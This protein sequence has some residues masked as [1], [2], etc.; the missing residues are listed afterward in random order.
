MEGEIYHVYNRG[1]HKS[2]IFGIP[3]DYNRFQ[4]LLYLANSRVPVDFREVLDRSE[5]RTF[6][7]IFD[8]S[9]DQS[10]VSVLAYCLMP[11]HFHLVVR[12][13]T[14]GGI[15]LF[16]RKLATAYSMYFNTKYEH[17]GT[18]F[19]GKFKSKHVDNDPYLRWIFSYVHLNPLE[20]VEPEWKDKG[21][22]NK[23]RARRYV[24]EYPYSSHTDYVRE[25]RAASIIV[26]FSESL[27]SLRGFD[28]FEYLLQW[29]ENDNQP[30][31]V[32]PSRTL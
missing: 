21:V 32:G 13:K 29:Q 19:Q 18:L 17:S 10:L 16:M 30:A 20:L 7:G 6:A 3:A 5:G 12:Q 24:A 31:K 4:A 2:A 23:E 22:Q 9:V 15:S 8:E 28:E 27:E 1:A 26:D 14:E 25:K 11:N